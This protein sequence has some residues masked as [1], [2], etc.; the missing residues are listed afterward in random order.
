MNYL[1]AH[2]LFTCLCLILAHYITLLEIANGLYED[3]YDYIREIKLLS[4]GILCL[5][6][7]ILNIAFFIVLCKCFSDQFTYFK[8]IRKELKELNDK[9]TSNPL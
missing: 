6:I 4:F 9:E 8:I 7:P 2:L 1:I 3:E 5:L